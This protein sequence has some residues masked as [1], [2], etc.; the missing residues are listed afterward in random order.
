MSNDIKENKSIPTL[1]LQGFR[2]NQFA[3]K[4]ELLFNE[5]FGEKVIEK[6]HKHDFFVII[7]FDK[8]SGIHNIDSIDYAIGNNE[9]HVLFP[10]QMHKWHIKEGTVGYQL[11]IEKSF[12][13]QFAPAF[14]FSFTNYQN[15][16]VISLNDDSFEQLLYEF[17]AIREELISVNPIIQLISA[18][19]AVIA[20]IVSKEAEL[21]IE[22]FKIYQTN[23]RL[24]KFNL[25][26]DKYYKEQKGISFYADQL[27]IS[28]NYLNILCKRNLK[29]SASHLIQQRIV[30][31]AKRLL[32]SSDISIKEI[33]YQLGFSDHA[34]F[35]NFFKNQTE[36]TPSQ[37]RDQL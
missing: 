32:Q 33:A 26:I 27:N 8:A 18:R 4:D 10:N 13:E 36:L 15:H 21:Y 30:I 17:I 34:Y 28:P 3:G 2:E 5:I 19:A 16:P 22:E 35:S 23:P 6:P 1:R 11:M 25:L 29:V 12:L 31:E 24:A 37:F 20:A 7:L 9:V 14:R